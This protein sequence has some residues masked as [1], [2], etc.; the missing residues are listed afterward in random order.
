MLQKMYFFKVHQTVIG[1]VNHQLSH[2]IFFL[3]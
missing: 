1:I 3:R 2:K